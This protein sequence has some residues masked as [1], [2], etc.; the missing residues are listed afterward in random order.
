MKVFTTVSEPNLLWQPLP[1]G[2]RETDGVIPGP[3]GRHPETSVVN[4][5]V[6]G[7]KE[8]EGKEMA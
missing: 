4:Q 6:D 5:E 1:T 7:E 2:A 3:E 8:V